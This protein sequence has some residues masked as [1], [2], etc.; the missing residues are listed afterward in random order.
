VNVFFG[1]VKRY[2]GM[3]MSIFTSNIGV[4][5][6][7]SIGLLGVLYAVLKRQLRTRGT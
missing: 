7:S 6:L 1:P 5:V 3:R 2:L 4:L